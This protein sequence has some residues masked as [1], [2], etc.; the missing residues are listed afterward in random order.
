MAYRI[1]KKGQNLRHWQW[2]GKIAFIVFCFGFASVSLA[3]PASTLVDLLNNLFS[4]IQLFLPER[5]LLE[6]P[7]GAWYLAAAKIL[8]ALT[9]ILIIAQ[10]VFQFYINQYQVWRLQDKKNHVVITGFG[11]C[12]QQF[13]LA[14]LERRQEVVAI[15]LEPSEQQQTFV[16]QNQN[17]TLL[18][19]EPNDRA[20]LLQSAAHKAE[21]VIFASHDNLVNIQG[22]THLRQLLKEEP[23]STQKT[24]HI[25]I[26][27]PDFVE[28][29]K[30]YP[31]FLK[32]DCT[33]KVISFNK[34]RIAARRLLLSYPLYQYAD[35]RGQ[36]RV[37]VAI[38]GFDLKGQQLALQLALNSYYRDFKAPHIIIVDPKATQRGQEFLSRYPGLKD[39]E[40]SK[41]SLIDFDIHAHALDVPNQDVL[42]AFKITNK[43]CAPGLPSF[44]Q[45]LEMQGQKESAYGQS[46]TAILL[47]FEKD[48]RN[49]TAALR[50]RIKSQQSRWALAP[51]FVEMTQEL[52][53]LSIPV[54]KT[55]HFEEVVQHFGQVEQICT[56][57]E[58]VEGC[59]DDLAKF[60]HEAYNAHY[61]NNQG[62]LWSDL[63]ED[64]R[65]ANRGAADH[66]GVKL[67]SV[68]YSV[69]GDPSHWSRTVDLTV[70]SEA[71]ELMAILEHRRWYAER[72][73][74]GWQY[75]RIRDNRRKIHPCLVSF[76]RLAD[77]EKEK[78]RNNID[79]LQA[80]FSSEIPNDMLN[81]ALS[82]LRQQWLGKHQG[83]KVRRAVNIALIVNEYLSADSSEIQTKLFDKNGLL[84]GL[85]KKYCN[86]H[87]TLMSTLQHPL[88]IEFAQMGL[89]QSARLIIPRAYPFDLPKAPKASNVE[90]DLI[91]T[92]S[93]LDISQKADWVIDLVPA[94][95]TLNSLTME[96]RTSL[97]QRAVIYQL[98]RADVV[99][100]VGENAQWLK[101]RQG[102]ETIPVDLSSLPPSLRGSRKIP[103]R[104]MDWI[105]NDKDVQS[106]L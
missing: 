47:C 78:D 24:A 64:L 23:S 56:W 31:H 98:E 25:Q 4:T 71:K 12:G 14:V 37:R 59:S 16:S 2:I 76:D 45:A 41:I 105:V 38:F 86:Y 43:E 95:K 36:D 42:P 68:G 74:N 20:T 22:V 79:D 82:A 58:M 10:V 48:Y 40:V 9:F 44:L 67:A 5:I 18:A 88:A 100:L 89:K 33:L 27:D 72:L 70:D 30:E 106:M 73:L 52:Q 103:S 35:L 15:D 13:A 50:L 7:E 80:Y 61:G 49:I 97:R 93:Q 53:A 1:Y 87:V 63:A 77:E 81:T 26:H 55:P 90:E 69:S 104:E 39:P 54:D 29:L 101:W 32:E 65:D 102:E 66:L 85:F 46:L 17:L 11:D 21:R 28:S 94:G 91:L 99:I 57:Q 3:Y 84:P 92:K 96:E 62:T 34:H 19:G 75:G 6:V 83:A 8:G 51:I 60:L